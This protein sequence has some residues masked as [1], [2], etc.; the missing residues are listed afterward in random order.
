MSSRKARFQSLAI[1]N[2]EL[3]CDQNVPFGLLACIGDRPG[4]VLA[5]D[6]RRNAYS[7]GA[8]Q[9]VDG[10]RQG[11][12]FFPLRGIWFLARFCNLSRSSDQ[13]ATIC[14][15]GYRRAVWRDR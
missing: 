1:A 3:N 12:A 10:E 4:A 15:L 11:C 14:R 7:F 8:Q 6:V 5:G 2:T 9:L 13:D